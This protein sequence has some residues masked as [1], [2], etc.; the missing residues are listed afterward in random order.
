MKI[1]LDSV[2][3]KDAVVLYEKREGNKRY[4]IG[5]I[6]TISNKIIFS[7]YEGLGSIQLDPALQE[8]FNLERI[9]DFVTKERIK[10]NG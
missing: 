3:G 5:I 6:E 1:F 2:A 10:R 8:R 7:S 9:I 4:N